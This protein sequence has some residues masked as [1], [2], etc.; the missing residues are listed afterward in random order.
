[1]PETKT[2]RTAVA[3][4]STKQPTKTAS[5]RGRKPIGDQAMSGSARQARYRQGLKIAS[6]DAISKPSE[7]SRPALMERL[8]EALVTLDD[9][10]KSK[11][12]DTHRAIAATVV[13][14]LKKRYE[15]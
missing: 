2:A 15:L 12:H 7:A 14:E 10:K 4:K 1:M 3:G 9:P 13:K 5:A 11:H 6:M 8:N